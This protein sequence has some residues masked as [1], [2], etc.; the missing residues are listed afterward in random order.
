MGATLI[1]IVY[2]IVTIVSIAAGG[3]LPKYFM[4]RRGMED[5]SGRLRAMLLFAFL[6][7]FSLFAHPWDN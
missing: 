6:P 4:E 1:F 5:Y 3:Y 7:V 2:L